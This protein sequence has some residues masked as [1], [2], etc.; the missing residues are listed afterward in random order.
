MLL[1][2]LVVILLP[3]F[4]GAIS[5]VTSS[6]DNRALCRKAML[7]RP[8]QGRNVLLFAATRACFR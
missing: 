6:A 4:H 3:L 1:L 2:L 7:L 8:T 5:K